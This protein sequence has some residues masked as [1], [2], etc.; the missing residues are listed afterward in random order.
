[1][2]NNDDSPVKEPP[3]IQENVDLTPLNTMGVSV[4][5][6]RFLEITHRNQLKH[7][8]KDGF[9]EREEPIVLGGGSNLLFVEEPE[10]PVLKVS[11]TG[12]KTTQDSDQHVILEA[13]AG[14]NWHKL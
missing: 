5:A 13:G 12:M 3:I 10:R 9:F 14:E 4:K 1:M 8:F 2:P 7:L 6:R 11:I